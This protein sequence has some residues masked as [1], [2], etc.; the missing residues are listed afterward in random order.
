MQEARFKE[1]LKGRFGIILP[2]YVAFEGEKTLRAMN[3]ELK[4]FKT[5]TPK[6]IRASRMK[7]AFPKPTT[8]F[9]QLFGNPATKNTIEVGREDALRYFQG[10]G[11]E[12][13]TPAQTGYVI[14][15][16][17]GAV[18]GIGFYREGE[19]ENMLPKGRKIRPIPK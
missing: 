2:G 10:N 4:E 9:I 17:M 1:Y 5:S 18:L 6:G 3:A 11:L 7:G 16:H 15:T 14:L 19:I 8:N 13:E 12:T